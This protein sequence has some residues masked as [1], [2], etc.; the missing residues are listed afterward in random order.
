MHGSK[1]ARVLVPGPLHEKALQRIDQNF[2]MVRQEAWRGQLLPADI[3]ASIRGICA[4]IPINADMMDA[5]PNL[6]IIAHFGV[7]YD[8]VDVGHAASRGIMVTHTPGVL[9]EDVADIAI[10]LLIN[11]VRELPRAERWLRDGQWASQGAYPLTKRTLQ[12][13]RAGIFGMGRVGLAVAQRLKAFGISIAYHNR[14]RV[15]GVDY[16][17][18]PTLIGLAEAVDTLI[19]VAPSTA[20]TARVI[21][22]KVFD[23]LGPNG[24]FIN[25]GR[26]KT[27]DQNDLIKALQNGV[28]AAA[29]LDV[30]AEEPNLPQAL[31]DLPTATLL[32][33]VGSATEN[34]R[35]A[36]ADL[37]VDNLLSWFAEGRAVTAVPETAHIKAAAA[38]PSGEPH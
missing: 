12:G 20:A 25:I 28:I 24:I 14:N 5:F 30:F 16:S 26:G 29:G 4:I 9:T 10:G 37:C 1:S 35:Q 2:A 38:R 27:V 15:E 34:S 8:S 22:A 33:H 6:E 21:D 31:L 13:R 11:A 17:F 19:S 36:M 23:A 18:Y 7:G 32:P 3:A